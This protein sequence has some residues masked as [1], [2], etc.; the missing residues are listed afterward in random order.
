MFGVYGVPADLDLRLLTGRSLIN[1]VL[2]TYNTVFSLNG[3]G[4]VNA[5][6]RW[7]VREVDGR[8]L[9]GRS[10]G[11]PSQPWWR[12]VFTVARS[13]RRVDGDL[14]SESL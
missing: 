10:R 14:R 4:G 5:E 12:P 2:G 8:V 3:N 11:E 13:D 7:E 1:I 6:G 9:G